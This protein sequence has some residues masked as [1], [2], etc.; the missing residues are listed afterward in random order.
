MFHVRLAGV[1]IQVENCFD[2][3]QKQYSA[4]LCPQED[5]PAF[6]VS[7]S[8]AEC[9]AESIVPAYGE[10]ISLCRKISA[11]L[12]TQ[13][14]LLLH[15]AAIDMAGEGYLF[16][17]RSGIG[18][19]THIRL[20]QQAFGDGVRVI[21][22][23]KPLLR[24]EADQLMVYGSPWRGKEQLGCK[25]KA[26]VK[27]LCFL[28]QAKENRLVRI[29]PEQAME[30][31]FHQVLMPQ[32]ADGMEKL[33]ALVERILMNAPCYVLHCRPDEQAARIAWEGLKEASGC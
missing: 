11:G 17:G 2:A 20:W 29:T 15:A 13:D 8:E 19:T 28:E 33:L 14:V 7:A 5:A 26:P 3:V 12:L 6:C 24:F 4:F 30:R 22:G 1:C 9:R 21:N 16:A 18:K 32:R 10:T 31:L 23:D 27:A 25:A